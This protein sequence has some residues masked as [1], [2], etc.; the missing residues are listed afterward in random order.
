MLEGLILEHPSLVCRLS[1]SGQTHEGCEL[2]GTQAEG[3]KTKEPAVVEAAA[4]RPPRKLVSDGGTKATAASPVIPQE[5][6]N[7][8]QRC[9]S[10]IHSSTLW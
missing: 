9:R 7:I 8:P 10:A 5:A 4:E 2:D 1:G 6:C 3:Q